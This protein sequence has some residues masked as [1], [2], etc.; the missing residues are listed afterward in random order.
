MQNQGVALDRQNRMYRFLEGL[1]GFSSIGFIVLIILLSIFTPTVASIILILYSFMWLMKYTLNVIYTLIVYKQLRR[2]S[3]INLVGIIELLEK[4][5]DSGIEKLHHISKLYPNKIAW[6]KNLE[7][8]ISILESNKNNKFANP[9]N[10][11]QI[12]NFAVYNESDI[13]L[14]SSLKRVLDCG[15][16]VDKMLVIISQEERIG[17]QFNKNIREKIASLSWTK[18]TDFTNLKPKEIFTKDFLQLRFNNQKLASL[19][20]DDTRL[21]IV[22]VQHPE[23]LVGEIKGKASNEDYGARFASLIIKAKKIDEEMVLVTSL[24]ADSALQPGFFHNLAYTFCTTENRQ[25]CGYQPVHSYSSNFFETSIWPRQVA[26]QTT[27]SNMTSLGISGETPF[28][29]IYSVPLNVL[30]SVGFWEKELIGEDFMLFTKC[31]VHYKGEFKVHPFFGVFEGDAVIGGDLLEEVVGQYKQLQRWAWGGVEAFPYMFRRFFIDS[32]GSKISTR[33]R[34][35]WIYLLFTNHFFW[36]SSPLLFSV[37]M[38][39]PTLLGGSDFRQQPI[40]F[41]L[42]TFSQYFSIISFIY[43]VA[44]GYIS[45]T[46]LARNA[47][48]GRS[49]SLVQSFMIFLQ[50]IISPFLFGLMGIPA[51]DAQI[52]GITG[53]YLGY[54]VTPKR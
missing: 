39:L 14:K 13:V 29:A 11:F 38:F 5:F 12:C 43:I 6:K 31:L 37:G 30:Y 17:E 10:V 2:W 4:N 53:N 27:L 41:S 50:F 54:W 24:D 32:V 48:G 47:N 26:M 22:F 8:Q 40:A 52:R 45:Y 36:S 1:L 44:F 35:R 7:N 16:P 15:Y 21:N 46:Y 42:A 18:V 9:K 23:N 51:L 3:K 28:F 49:P 33:Y 20:L 19:K 34:L 25:N